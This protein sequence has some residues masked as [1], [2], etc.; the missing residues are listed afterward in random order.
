MYSTVKSAAGG[1][2]V[3]SV[4][5]QPRASS[6]HDITRR[7]HLPSR[8][9]EGA[10][11][12]CTLGVADED[13]DVT[14]VDELVDVADLLYKRSAAEHAQVVRCRLPSMPSLIGCAIGEALRREPVL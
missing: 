11:R 12:L 8:R 4:Q 7:A 13:P 10:I 1:A 6:K 2:P 9:I 5:S 14:P 3:V